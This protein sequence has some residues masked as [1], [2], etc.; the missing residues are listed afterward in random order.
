MDFKELIK[1]AN[2]GYSVVDGDIDLT[3][4]DPT[5][6]M[7][8]RF[9]HGDP[10]AEFVVREIHDT[11]DLFASDEA[12]LAEAIRVMRMAQRDLENTADALEKALGRGEKIFLSFSERA[13]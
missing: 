9:Y 2:A 1:I 6:A 12:Q 8:D 3:Q 10:L 11:F 5:T 7:E 13:V 4:I